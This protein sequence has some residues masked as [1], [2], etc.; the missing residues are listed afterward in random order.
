MSRRP[1]RGEYI[2]TDTGNKVARK[3]TL[4]GTQN[5]MLG[6]KTVIQPEVMI[7]GDLIRT[8]QTSSHSASGAAPNNTAVSI[9]RY[10]FLSRGCCLRPPGRMYKGCVLTTLPSDS[11]R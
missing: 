10:C 5:I 3:A 2:E 11:P 9:G 1:P 6:G 8:I 4:V 7:R